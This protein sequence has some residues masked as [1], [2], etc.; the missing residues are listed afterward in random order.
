MSYDEPKPST[1]AP[2]ITPADRARLLAEAQ[3]R[4]AEAL[5]DRP[6]VTAPAS[7][8][9]ADEIAGRIDHTALSATTMQDDIAVLC[10]EAREHGFASICVNPRWVPLAAR[11]LA[12]TGVMVCTV[13]AFPLGAAATSVKSAETLRAVAD[14]ANEIDMVI[15]IASLIRGDLGAV[16]DDI[17]AVVVAADGVPVKAIIEACLLT[18]EQKAMACLTAARAGAAYVKTSTGFS[19]GGATL[20]DVALMRACVGNDLGVKASGGVRTRED[21]ERMLDAGADRIGTSA[22]C[23]IV[24]ER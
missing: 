23:T 9:D 7:V 11:L 8:R 2:S 4:V 3:E 6:A 24:Q 5:A 22:S 13:V 10:G 16:Y 14:G 21:A 18:D 20:D 15:D 1:P 17:H 19:T 12:D